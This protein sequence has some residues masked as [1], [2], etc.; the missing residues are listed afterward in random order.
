MLRDHIRS[1]IR[2]MWE[3]V[4]SDVLLG[5]PLEDLAVFEHSH[6][7]VEEA[8]CLGEGKF[9]ELLNR[10]CQPLVPPEN[11]SF[12]CGSRPGP[13]WQHAKATFYLAE[14]EAAGVVELKCDLVPNTD[15]A[16]TTLL[17]TMMVTPRLPNGAAGYPRTNSQP[18]RASITREGP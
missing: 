14:T 13:F 7:K 5:I 4:A 18:I 16:S 1:D 17:S 6:A 10:K 12:D 11:Y 15:A 8:R 2:E 9:V 3:K